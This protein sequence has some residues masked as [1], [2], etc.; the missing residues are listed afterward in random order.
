MDIQSALIG[1]RDPMGIPF[2]PWLFQGLMVLTFALHILLVN[3]VVGGICLAVYHHFKGGEYGTLLSK[4]MARCSTVNLSLAIVLGVAPLLFIQVIYDP[5]WYA[6]NSISAW[7]AM[8]FLLVTTLGFLSLYVFYLKRAKQPSGF[9]IFGIFSLAMV[10]FAGVIMSMFAMQQLLPE[11]WLSWYIVNDSLQT[12]GGSFHAFSLGR[13]LHFMVPAFI[14]I[15]IYMMLYAWYFR[16]RPD[17]DQNYLDWVG[18]TGARMAKIAAMVQVVIGF[19]WLF[20]V[21]MK[22][23]FYSNPLFLLGAALGVLVMVLLMAGQKD[24]DRYALPLGILSL[25]AV[26]GMST[27]REVLR[28]SYL[29]QFDYSV[30]QYPVNLDLGSTALFLVTFIMGLVVIAYPITIA[31]KL[32]RGTLSVEEG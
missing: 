15:G 1:L 12:L 23:S 32:G 2:F 29:G 27:A 24:P 8:V 13:F 7:W 17:F 30:Y 28:M 3:L 25:V 26:L 10:V 9:G 4:T 31:F 19:W 6:A 22:F 14:N 18:K 20:T 21:P 5:F 16:P 11:K